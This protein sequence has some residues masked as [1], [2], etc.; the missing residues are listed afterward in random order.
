MKKITYSSAGDNYDTK[1]PIKKLAQ[2]SA[3]STAQNLKIN[4]F[5]EMP[6]SRGESAYV[7]SKG[8]ELYASVIEGLGTKNLVADEVRKITGKTYYEEIAH[9]TIATIINDLVSVGA[10]PL[11]VHAY[12]A[13]GNNIWLEDDQRMKDLITGFKKACDISM[14][15]WGGGETPTLKGI[16]KKETIVLGGS[17]F[18]IIGDPKYYLNEQ[19]LEDGDRIILIKSNGLNTNGAS[20]VRAIAKRIPKGY[21]HILRNGKLFG[22][23]ALERSN[24]YARLIRDLLEND[25]DVHYISHLTGHGLRKIMRAKASFTYFLEKI[26]VPS[27]L[28]QFIQK[29]AGLS[30]YEMYSTFNMGQDYALFVKS[31]DT[32]KTLEIIK[33]NKFQGF[34]AGFIQKGERKVVIQP[35]N[36]LYEGNTL[37]LRT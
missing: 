20:L 4:D 6:G 12:W 34:D 26:A 14:A 7:F 17:A 10:R 27:E 36:I 28:F 30:S 5:K 35:L 32:K 24:I 11:V 22:E 18:G 2:K 29:R 13:I 23:E 25:I 9:D 21:A 15:S 19:R 3:F 33:R 37:D 8:K 16:I 1:D 31:R